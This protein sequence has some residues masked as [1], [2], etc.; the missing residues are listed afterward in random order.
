MSI[1]FQTRAVVGQILPVKMVCM[2]PSSLKYSRSI[3]S[4]SVKHA[5]NT[6]DDA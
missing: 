3:G 2:N 1:I 5:V 6:V 4:L